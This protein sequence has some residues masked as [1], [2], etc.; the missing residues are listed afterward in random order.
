MVPVSD[1]KEF[2]FLLDINQDHNNT[3][4]PHQSLLS[5]DQ[6]EIFT[7]GSGNST[8]TN[9]STLG[10]L[11]YNL[12]ANANHWIE[13]NA[14]LS[15][16]SGSADM[17]AYIP[18]SLFGTGNPYVTLYSQF[19]SNYAANGGFEEWAVEKASSTTSVP[20]PASLLLLGSGLVG[21]ALLGRK[22]LLN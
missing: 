6:L 1:C 13:L 19:G 16:G 7:G 17:Y 12:D 22:K 5:L 4:N 14:A 15:H 21:F 18:D 20:E 9:I 11:I 10:T 3:A 8:T 2:K